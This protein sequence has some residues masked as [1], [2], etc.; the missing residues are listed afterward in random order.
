MFFKT[1]IKG[2]SEGLIMETNE[3]LNQAV[4][5]NALLALLCQ[6]VIE[7]HGSSLKYRGK[8]EE[9]MKQ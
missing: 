2:L 3:R 7:T 5:T 8:L 9:I 4:T 6:I 1:F